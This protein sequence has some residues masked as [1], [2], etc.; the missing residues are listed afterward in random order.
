MPFAVQKGEDRQSQEKYQVRDLIFFSQYNKKKLPI[1]LR[2][3][4]MI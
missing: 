1:F 3:F 2:Q 4:L